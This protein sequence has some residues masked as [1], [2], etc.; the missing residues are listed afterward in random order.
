MVLVLTDAR[1]VAICGE[2]F[3]V[4]VNLPL[5]FECQMKSSFLA[6]LRRG[7]VCVRVCCVFSFV[8]AKYYK[9]QQTILSHNL[10]YF[11]FN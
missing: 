11:C 10:S 4:F 6:R 1:Q 9:L 3:E 7:L 8:L 2:S 5:C